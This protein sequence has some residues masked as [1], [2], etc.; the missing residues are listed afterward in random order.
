MR[1]SSGGIFHRAHAGAA[2]IDGMLDDYAF[3]VWGLTEL[4][5]AT[6]DVQY[7][8]EALGLHTAADERFTDGAGGWFM[9]ATGAE[10]LLVRPRESYDGALP[11]GQAVMTWNALRLARM[12]GDWT[13]EESAHRAL[14]S[15]AG[16][17]AYPDAHT[18]WMVAL[19]FGVGPAQEVVIAGDAGAADTMA[20]RAAMDRA[21]AP[22]AVVL[23][24]AP[25]AGD[26][27]I[28][29][30]APFTREQT[31]IDGRASAYVCERHACRAPT[32]DPSAAVRMLAQG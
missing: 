6:G 16:V 1:D 24:R 22:N 31:A 27:P 7:L 25:G 30:L 32:F 5:Q 14:G 4:Y 23:H 13:L 8:R 9:A 28:A 2:G 15:D 12:T 17:A 21:W 19:S 18:F 10:D 3:V 11:S 26:P 20:M 29:E